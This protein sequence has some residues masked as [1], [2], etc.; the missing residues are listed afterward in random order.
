[1]ESEAAKFGICRIVPPPEWR[2][3]LALRMDSART[4]A[5][6]LQRIDTLQEGVPFDDGGEYTLGTYRARADGFA[7]AWAAQHHGGT[8]PSNEV[9][10]AEYWDM[11]TTGSRS[12]AVEYGND[13]DTT[14]VGSGFPRSAAGAGTGGEPA[15]SSA[16]YYARTGWNLNNLPSIEGS[17]LRHV[18]APINGVNVPWLYCGMQFST[19]CWHN[20]DNYLYS[21]NYSHAGADKQWYGVPGAQARA[22]EKVRPAAAAAASAA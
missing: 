19:F 12:A 7:V 1:M 20:E 18:R 10:C 17:V 16:D 9:L 2:P 14:E 4:F 21:I 6:K 11:V 15:M 22:F 5:T 3:P 8:A 13:L